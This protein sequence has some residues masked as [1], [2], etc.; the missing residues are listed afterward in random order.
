MNWLV[1]DVPEDLAE[2]EFGDQ[3]SGAMAALAMAV[4]V[5]LLCAGTVAVV[6]FMS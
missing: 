1:K 5:G 4:I 2:A 3:P 6:A